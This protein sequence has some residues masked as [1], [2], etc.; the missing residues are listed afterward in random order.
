MLGRRKDLLDLVVPA[1]A[2][3]PSVSA[4]ALIA[5]PRLLVLKKLYD[6]FCA[7]ADGCDYGSRLKAGTT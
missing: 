4:I 3:T 7:I 2:G 5:T 1:T 6:G